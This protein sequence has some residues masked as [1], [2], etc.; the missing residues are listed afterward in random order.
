M[1]LV[2]VED[3][4]EGMAVDL[5]NDQYA[6][7]FGHRGYER[8]PEDGLGEGDHMMFESELARVQVLE[9]E[10]KAGEY[11]TVVVEFDL[12]TCGFPRGHKVKVDE[13]AGDGAE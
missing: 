3:L 9:F 4:K 1:K 11:D 7:A 2:A 12:T 10:Y 6:D 8:D 13:T 5:E